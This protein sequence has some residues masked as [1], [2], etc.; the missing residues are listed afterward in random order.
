[1][2]EKRYHHGDLRSKLF[3]MLMS[4]VTSESLNDF[5]LREAAR[6]IG[7]S[8]AAPYNHFPDKKSLIEYSINRSRSIFLNYLKQYS[9]DKVNSKNTLKRLGKSYIKYSYNNP[10]IFVFI[11]SQR[12][13][14]KEKSS[15]FCDL[16]SLFLEAVSFDI[17]E[18]KLRKNITMESAAYSAWSMIHGLAY[19]IASGEMSSKEKNTI[20]VDELFNKI[21]SIWV[22]GVTRPLAMN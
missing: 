22:I 20:D 9:F 2:K 10:K 8:S 1:M 19:F 16:K 6:V 11:F 21:F 4:S 12:I 13:N 5:S 18:E 14:I 17:Q 3:K 7:V 15:Y